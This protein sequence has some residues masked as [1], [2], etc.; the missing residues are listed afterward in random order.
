MNVNALCRH[1]GLA[2][3]TVSH[4]LGLMRAG[5]LVSGRREG[6]QVFYSLNE[7]TVSRLNPH[8][9]LAIAAGPLQLRLMAASESGQPVEAAQGVA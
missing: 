9:G 3:P 1:L 6:K 8:G 4:H 5:G 7:R 2:Q